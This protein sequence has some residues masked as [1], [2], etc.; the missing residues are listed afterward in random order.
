MPCWRASPRRATP[1]ISRVSTSSSKPSSRT[2]NSSTRCSRRSKT[3]SSPMRSSG[4]TPPRCRSPAWQPASNGRKTSSGS[5]SSHRWTRC[6]WSKSSRARRLLTR[7]WPGCSTTR[8]PSARPRS[9]STTAA[10][11][12]PHGSSAPSSTRRWLCSARAWNRRRSSRPGRRPGT[13]P[14][15]CSS[16]TSS[17]WSSC[18]RSPSLP[19]RVS[20]MPA[21][22]TSRI[23]PRRL[24]RR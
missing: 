12:S 4:P 16:P 22:P 24:S 20:R 14:R 13:R 23:R 18:T 1:R 15:R 17:T 21:A 10:G 8:W 19:V 6:R 11:S 9:W 2:R 5:T 7:R 3:S